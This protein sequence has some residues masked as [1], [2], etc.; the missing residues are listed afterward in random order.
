[1]AEILIEPYR[2]MANHYLTQQTAAIKF[3]TFET[4][5]IIYHEST[6]NLNFSIPDFP[7]KL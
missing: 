1:M 3:E 4:K 7:F 2:N 6:I 5:K